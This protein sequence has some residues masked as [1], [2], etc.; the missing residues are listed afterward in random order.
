MVQEVEVSRDNNTC[1]VDLEWSNSPCVLRFFI[2]IA[3]QSSRLL[4]APVLLLSHVNQLPE[5]PSPYQRAGK[6]LIQLI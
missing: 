2:E 5:K 6:S 4:D 3:N 1:H